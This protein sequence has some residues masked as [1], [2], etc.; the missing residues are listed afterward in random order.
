MQPERFDE[1]MKGFGD[2][3]CKVTWIKALARF[4]AML[5]YKSCLDSWALI[6][7]SFNFTPDRWDYEY[8]NEILDEFLMYADGLEI[9][10]DGLEHLFSEDFSAQEREEANGFFR[11]VAERE[12][13]HRGI[14]LTD[15]P[16]GA[17]AGTYT[18]A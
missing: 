9:I 13:N 6:T 11:L 16:I 8:R 14:G 7:I 10:R 1:E 4:E 5:T 15:G 18:A 12:R 17:I 2:R 3:R